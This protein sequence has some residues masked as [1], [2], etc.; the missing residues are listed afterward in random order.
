M[1]SGQ[2]FLLSRQGLN[3]PKAQNNPHTT[4]AYHGETFSEPPHHEVLSRFILITLWLH[5]E[6]GVCLSG[7]GL[8]FYI[9]QVHCKFLD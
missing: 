3:C 5:E 8:N 7:D 9:A 2:R 4:E 1:G 6:N